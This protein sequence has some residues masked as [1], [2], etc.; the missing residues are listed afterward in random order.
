MHYETFGSMNGKGIPAYAT[1]KAPSGDWVYAKDG[2]TQLKVGDGA[3]VVPFNIVSD[4]GKYAKYELSTGKDVWLEM[5]HIRKVDYVPPSNT[6]TYKIKIL[7]HEFMAEV[8][9]II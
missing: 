3:V 7:G 8:E 9:E 2:I 5:S 1:K 6:R 4:T